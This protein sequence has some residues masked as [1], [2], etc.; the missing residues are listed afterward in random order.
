MEATHIEVG[1]PHPEEAAELNDNEAIQFSASLPP[2]Q[3]AISVGG[4][5]A[6]IKIDVPQTDLAGV[7]RL[8]AFGQGKLLKVTV[9]IEG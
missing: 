6:R 2:I 1:A 3:S 4:D 8:A 7:L 5:G 9:E